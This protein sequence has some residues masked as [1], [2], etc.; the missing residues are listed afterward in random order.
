VNDKDAV[1]ATALDY[2][3]G[4]YDA[5]LKRVERALHPQLVK[6]WAAQTGGEQPSV[7]T[8]EMMLDFVRR[9]GG[10]ED[11]TDD[12]IEVD[13]VDIY[14]DISTAVVRSAQYRE[15]LHLIRTPDGW[16]IVNAFWQFT[17]PDRGA[18]S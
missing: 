16:R 9:G 17:Q 12:P 8:K 5:D 3:E 1:V 14:R 7:T 13:V 6:R 18:Q 2:F 4:W 10:V 11:K 15:Y